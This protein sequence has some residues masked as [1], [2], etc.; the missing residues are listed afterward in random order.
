L[1]RGPGN[2]FFK[3]NTTNGIPERYDIVYGALFEN[4]PYQF[5]VYIEAIELTVP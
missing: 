3:I 1:T 5:E 2:Y 4:N